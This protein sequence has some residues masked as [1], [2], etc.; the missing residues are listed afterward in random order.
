[1]AVGGYLCFNLFFNIFTMLVIKH[2]SATLAF[3]VSTL[4]MPISAVA[5]SSELIMGDDAVRPGA[6]DLFSL[7]VILAG[8][9][10]YRYGGRLLKREQRRPSQTATTTSSPLWPSPSDMWPSP[11]DKPGGVSSSARKWK[12]APIFS[13]GT[14]A[15]QP[16]FVYV[17]AVVVQPRSSLRV[18][19]DLIHR[20]GAGS[21]LNS[22]QLR[23]LSPDRSPRHS[24]RGSRVSES[25]DDG[26]LLLPPS[27]TGL[28]QL[29]M[30]SFP[31][32][33]GSNKESDFSLV[34]IQ[35]VE[36]PP[37]GSRVQSSSKTS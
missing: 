21:P 20:L 26:V 1:M 36:T 28:D 22:P 30:P 5:F 14:P 11:S 33:T 24:P 17:P 29:Q 32:S 6:S 2:G 23:S 12:F 7:V 25:L 35:D 18:R 16:I 27:A 37:P 15:L 13:M 31:G 3:L 4:R 19:T 9:G 10:A 8:L 34:G